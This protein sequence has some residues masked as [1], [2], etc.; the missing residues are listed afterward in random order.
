MSETK[1]YYVV[2]IGRQTGVYDE[3]SDVEELVKGYPGAKYKSF[4]TSAE[5]T[6]AYREGFGSEETAELGALIGEA[7]ARNA[8]RRNPATSR[9]AWE[10]FPEIDPKAWAV[11]AACSGNPGVM[12]YRGVEVATGREIFRVGPFKKATNNIGEFLAI[13]HALAL[14]Q[15][16][17]LHCTIYSDSRIGMG[18]VIKGRCNTKLEPSADNAGVRRLIARAEQWLGTHSIHVPLLKWNTEKWGEIPADFGRK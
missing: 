8:T 12:E 15:Q 10:E 13:V 2:W 6:R 3:W 7:S 14:Q 17:G 5:A 16:Q 4:K 1:K 18:W 11:D 9:M